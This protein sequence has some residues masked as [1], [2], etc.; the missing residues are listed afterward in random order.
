M[1]LRQQE[2]EIR[3][4]ILH[5]TRNELDQERTSTPIDL[6]VVVSGSRENQIDRKLQRA[7]TIYNES[8]HAKKGLSESYS[9]RDT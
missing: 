5:Q 7:L 3:Y 4:R 2:H 9:Q 6:D 1:L 8:V